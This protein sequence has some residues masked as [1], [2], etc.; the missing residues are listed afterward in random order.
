MPT[1][2]LIKF[3]C[4]I[5]AAYL[6]GSVSFAVLISRLV[7]KEDVR[8]KGSGNAGSTNMLRNYGAKLAALTFLGDF[9][10]GTLAVQLGFWL[11]GGT[12]YDKICA[13]VCAIVA[14]LGHTKPVFFSFRGGKGV[15]TALGGIMMWNTTV[16]LPVILL[17]FLMAGI[18]G[19]VSLAAITLASLFPVGV[20]LWVAMGKGQPSEILIALALALFVIY[21]HRENIVRLRNGT[22]RNIRRK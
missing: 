9:L 1:I 4:A 7:A 13:G 16:F 18:T 11:L 15:A 20:A 5:V 6:L 17:G 12:P 2:L 22:E 14:L 8:T 21:N 10:K 3:I 19:F